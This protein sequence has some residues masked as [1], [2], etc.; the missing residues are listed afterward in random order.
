MPPTTHE[1]YELFVRES[2]LTPDEKDDWLAF[3]AVLSEEDLLPYLEVLKEEPESLA[4]I[5]EGAV[6]GSEYMRTRDPELLDEI[7]RRSAEN[8]NDIFESSS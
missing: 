5:T 4:R 8:L 6:L 1:V 2:G 3:G 7:A